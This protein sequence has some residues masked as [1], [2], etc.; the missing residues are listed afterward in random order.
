MS[1]EVTNIKIWAEASANTLLMEAAQGVYESGSGELTIPHPVFHQLSQKTIDERSVT[2][3][4]T[5]YVDGNQK[6]AAAA[7]APAGGPPPVP[8]RLSRRK[9][10]MKSLTFKELQGRGVKLEKA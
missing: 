1:V 3:Y 5:V 7:A 4:L 8:V 6:A 2:G 9:M 10:K